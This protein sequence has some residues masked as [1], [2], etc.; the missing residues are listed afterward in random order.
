MEL[1]LHALMYIFRLGV[2]IFHWIIIHVIVHKL[3][4]T[5]EVKKFFR[6]LSSEHTLIFIAISSIYNT[7]SF[8]FPMIYC[9][10]TLLNVTEL[11]KN[12]LCFLKQSWK[13]VRWYYTFMGFLVV[14]KLEYYWN[15]KIFL[16]LKF[17]K[18]DQFF[19]FVWQGKQFKW[20]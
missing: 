4:P 9:Y 11:R 12:V 16:D 18:I 15:L 2:F 14:A 8:H 10:M 7:C 13:R 6:Y 3:F 17:I 1:F 5:L 19:S 20:W